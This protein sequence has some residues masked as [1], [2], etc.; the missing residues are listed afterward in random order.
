MLRELQGRLGTQSVIGVPSRATEFWMNK[1]EPRRYRLG[2]VRIRVTNCKYI[3]TL[4]PARY[5]PTP[6]KVWRTWVFASENQNETPCK[7][8]LP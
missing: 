7:Q 5:R 6:Y 1:T 3:Y 2:D 4:R 8:D